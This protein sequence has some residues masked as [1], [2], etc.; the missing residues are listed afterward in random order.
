MELQRAQKMEAVGQLTGGVA[1]DF[2]NLLGII[3]GNLDMLEDEVTGNGPAMRQCESAIKAALRGSYLTKR[4][5]AFSSH[6]TPETTP[7]NI[8]HVVS[9]ILNMIEKSLTASI[10]VETALADDLWLTNINAGEL[11]DALINLAV[12]AR[13]AMP[14]GGC[15]GIRTRNTTLDT[16]YI[17]DHPSVKPG[18][19]VEL[20]I[21]DNGTGIPEEM[22]E[23]IYEP[24][25][26]T[27][28][29]GQGT[30]LGLSMV[31]GFTQSIGGHMQTQSQPDHGTTVSILLPRS[32]NIPATDNIAKPDKTTGHRGNETILV[33][34]D[35]PELALS[36]KIS[37]NRL[38]YRVFTAHNASEALKTLDGERRSM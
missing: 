22:L 27:K 20:S 36:T 11:E 24:F 33:V 25:F 3:I 35:E 16:D 32:S 8:N 37:L 12:N 4:L 9:G 38:G 13:D 1:H 29:S 21:T 23:R 6:A 17:A 30:G 2:N 19:Y 18:E 28:A 10:R 26:T 31:Y 5:L 34:D 14:N 7:R 15:L